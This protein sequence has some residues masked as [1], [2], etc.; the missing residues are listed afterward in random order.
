MAS[1]QIFLRQELAN[2]WQGQD[3]FSNVRQLEG[4]VYR[5][6]EGRKTLRFDLNDKPYFAK[7]HQG[8]GWSEIIKNI[9]QLRAPVISAK[10]EWTAIKFL[11][12]H[13]IDTMTIAAYG[14]RGRNPAKVESFII[15]DE[16]T[17]TMSLE[18]LGQQ[19]Q[20]T[21]PTFNTKNCLINK[22]A[23]ISKTMHEQG[24]NHR[25]YYLCH[26]LLDENF[27]THNVIDDSTQLFL[28]DLH[29]AQIRNK[30]PLRWIIKDIGSLYYSAA[31]VPLTQRDLF[32]FMKTY[33]GMSLRETLDKQHDFWLNVAKR[34]DKLINQ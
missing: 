1:T 31:Q 3:V 23:N 5:D 30:T 22:L 12:K 34:A 19:W 11:E 18:H 27:A 10:N 28:I 20:Q 24:M 33:S 4:D 25:D 13:G 17:N 26:F 6:K 9:V 14:E 15:T 16:L 7:V 8:V 29:R 2:S 21:P 32:R